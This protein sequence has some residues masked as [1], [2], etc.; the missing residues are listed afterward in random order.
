MQVITEYRHANGFLPG[1]S[2]Q[3]ARRRQ[4]DSMAALERRVS[5]TVI[6]MPIPKLQR[7]A[8][9]AGL[10]EDRFLYDFAWRDEESESRIRA[11]DFDD[12]L[13]L[14]PGV[15]AWLVRLAGVLRPIVQQRWAAFVADRSRGSVEA[16]W[17]DEFLFGATR[18]GLD[19]VRDPLLSAQGQACFYCGDRVP[20]GSAQIDHFIPWVRHPDNGLDNLVA[21]HARC[22]NN[23][24]DAF[25][26]SDHLQRWVDR[27]TATDG[28]FADVRAQ[29][30]WPSDA[31]RSFGAARALYLWLPAGTPLWRGVG[32][33]SR[34]DPAELRSILVAAPT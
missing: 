18:I 33:F 28:P 29:L 23:K 17:L 15:G 16:A 34:A 6:R 20:A 8:S 13:H 21:A 4:P 12:T 11:A 14:R 5:T 3:E 7:M 25:A 9:G 27:M 22:N 1:A 26:A 2:I 10:T 31:G 30:A 32:I 19:R 24:R